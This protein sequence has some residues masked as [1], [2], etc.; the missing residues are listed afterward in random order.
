VYPGS[1]DRANSLS[2]GRRAAVGAGLL[3]LV[4]SLSV[5]L[6]AWLTLGQ[7]RVAVRG[8][9]MV[10]LLDEHELVLVD[11]LAYRLGRPSRGDVALVRSRPSTGRSGR[12]ALLLKRVVGLPGEVV[13]LA[14]DRLLIDGRPLDLGRPVVGSSPGSWSLGCAEYFLLSENLAL[15]TDSR[16][17]GPVARADLLGRAWL[18]YAPHVRML[19]RRAIRPADPADARPAQTRNVTQ[20]I[21]TN[22]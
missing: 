15:G 22:A 1:E 8:R 16:H 13:T 3:V 6:A 9:S 21:V 18:V 11:R 2:G 12:P 14:R 5:L 20:A 17:T 19:P 4:L 7:R 10:P